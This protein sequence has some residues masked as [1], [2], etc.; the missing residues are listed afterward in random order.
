MILIQKM[1]MVRCKCFISFSNPPF[2]KFLIIY[3]LY[4]DKLTN[5]LSTKFRDMIILLKVQRV[6]NLW[7]IRE[8]L[9]KHVYATGRKVGE[10]NLHR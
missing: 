9:S 3:P 4:Y 2:S 6:N 10:R 8:N 7:M 5:I 1:N